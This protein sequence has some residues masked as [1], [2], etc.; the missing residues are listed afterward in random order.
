MFVTFSKAVS[1]RRSG[2]LLVTMYI[3]KELH[4]ERNIL[5]RSQVLV[6]NANDELE[7][8]EVVCS[9]MTHYHR[10][11]KHFYVRRLVSPTSHK[12]ER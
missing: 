2:P 7:E 11:S 6:E 12:K 5:S 1:S 4:N 8:L 3:Q 9:N 10:R